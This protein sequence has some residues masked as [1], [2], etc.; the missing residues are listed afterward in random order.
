MKIKK[1]RRGAH[2]SEVKIKNRER[3]LSFF[4]EN[5]D[6]TYAKASEALD[7]SLHTVFRHVKDAEAGR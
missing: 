5:P 4:S 1:D 6:A 2:C 3:I 7:L